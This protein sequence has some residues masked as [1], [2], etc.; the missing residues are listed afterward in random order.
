MKRRVVH[1]LSAFVI[2]VVYGGQVCPFLE[3]LTIVQ[4]STPILI[5][6][7]VLF[8]LQ[9]AYFRGLVSKASSKFQSRLAFQFE[10][11]AFVV[12]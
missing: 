11:G 9:A 2:L 10:L 7:A 1:Y 8:L 3:S 5:T 4:L 12:A 6:L